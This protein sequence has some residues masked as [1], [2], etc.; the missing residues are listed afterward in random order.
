MERGTRTLASCLCA[1]L[2]AAVAA[3]AA[4]ADETCQSPYLPKL[5]GQEDFVYI[6]T[7]GIE[8]VGDGSDKLVTVGAN[9][10]R[11]DYGKVVSSAS[12]GGRHE[13]HHSGFSDDRRTLWAGGLDDS[14]IFL[15]DVA[16]DPA[17][18]AL[19]RIIS[20]FK[21]KTGGVV[22]PHG[23]YA[24][25]GR[26]LISALSS[27]DGSGKTA[28]VEYNNEGEFI[29]T[30]WM[31]DDA[32]YGYD[33]RVKPELNRLLTS[34][35]TG[36]TNYMR[37]LPELLGDAEAM[38]NFGQ[39]MVVWDY[40]ARKPLQTLAVPGAPLEIRWGV[41]ADH[42]YAFTAAALTS[43][44]WGIFRRA[45]GSFEAVELADIGDPAQ[46]PLP[47]DI[48]ISADDR[49]LFV[50]T[51]MD[52]KVRVYDVSD[53]R[54]P[55]MVYERVIGPQVNMVSQTW[56][57]KRVY[58]TSSLLANWDGIKGDDAQFLRAFGWDGKQLTPAFEIDFRAAELGR[59]HMMAFGQIDFHRGNLASAA[60]AGLG[61]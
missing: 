60:T 21:E 29:R 1:V 36:H 9:P 30:T 43:K 48:S 23:F 26:M 42:P 33:A 34:S 22:G 20:D 17:K 46:T 6:W 53:P 49:F 31:P 4:H 25:P 52:G 13:A 59:P 57:G 50:D 40:H 28:L 44:L 41:R 45:D 3:P 58:F 24:L 55:V 18:P 15:F 12:V 32:P 39:A 37:K 16:T 35:F 14:V 10:A 47:V 27:A 61:D 51:F 56:D 11:D 7:L 8:G 5:E 38:K 19:I 54:K 2:A